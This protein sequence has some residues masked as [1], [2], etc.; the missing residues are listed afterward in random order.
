MSKLT[1]ETQLLIEE[2]QDGQ[3]YVTR[4]F[5]VRAHR[6]LEGYD[7]VCDRYFAVA[8]ALGK[9]EATP[10]IP[11]RVARIFA[12]LKKAEWHI[13]LSAQFS[14]PKAEIQALAAELRDALAIYPLRGDA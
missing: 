13:A 4:D 8:Q 9:E 3:V 11:D 2:C 14:H 10:D 12:A 6:A 1:R 5:L 7:I